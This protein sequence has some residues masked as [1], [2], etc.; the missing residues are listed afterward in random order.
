MNENKKK[1]ISC[2]AR[3]NE[4]WSKYEKSDKNVHY[5]FFFFF[6]FELKL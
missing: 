5:F 1:K 2:K 3:L 4:I 6:W